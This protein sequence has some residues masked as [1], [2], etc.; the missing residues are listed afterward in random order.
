VNKGRWVNPEEN[1]AIVVNDA[2]WNT[3]PDLKPGDQILLEIR[4]KEDFWTVVG[5][6]HYTG[7]DEKFAYTTFGTLAQDLNSPNH[8]STYRVV[9]AEHTLDFQMDMAQKIE[10]QLT[11]AGYNVAGTTAQQEIVKEGLE[12][13]NVIIYVL[14]FLSVLTGIVGGI[15]LSGTLSLNVLERTAEIGILRAIGAYNKII[16]RLVMFE[17]LFIG[18]TSY[19]IG[20]VISFPISYVLT[21]LVNSAIF[22]ASSAFVITPKG[23]ILWF[24]ILLILSLVASYFPAKNAA[25]LTIREVLAYE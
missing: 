7:L 1:H 22:G 6:F 24:F 23:F 8:T 20:I 3:Y 9:T 5:I 16:T 13:M 19:L 21:N 11:S 18:L 25:S 17:S 10:D 2:F 4:G 15:G 14:L 12:K